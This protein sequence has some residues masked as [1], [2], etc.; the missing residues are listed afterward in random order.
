MSCSFQWNHFYQA[1]FMSEQD[2]RCSVLMGGN[3]CFIIKLITC[4]EAY[5][6]V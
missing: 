6:N 4:D 3:N 2:K 5:E 1:K